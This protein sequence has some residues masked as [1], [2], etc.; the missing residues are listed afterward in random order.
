[1]ELE[2]REKISLA[3]RQR[4][5]TQ[6]RL[7]SL[8]GIDMQTY[9]RWE[10]GIIKKIPLE[11]IVKIAEVTGKPI[12][13]FLSEI[14]ETKLKVQ[15]ST[16]T[17]N[18]HPIDTGGL[19][20]IP[21]LGII[22]GGNIDLFIDTPP[23]FLTLDKKIL[24]NQNCVA[25]RISGD[26]LIDARIHDGD[27]VLVSKDEK[28]KNGDIAVVRIDNEITCKIVSLLEDG[29]LLLES[30]NKANPWKRV[31]DPKKNSIRIIGLVTQAIMQFK[32]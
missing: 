22:P 29:Q 24:V 13:Y 28:V 25:F 14:D 12:A 26:C 3:R 8:I 18:A 6:S 4:K 23:D 11:A 5:L 19:L 27:Y 20:Q 17:Y 7:A 30:A 16:A 1:M 21:V 2:L 9:S 32:K 10:R 31:I 15:E